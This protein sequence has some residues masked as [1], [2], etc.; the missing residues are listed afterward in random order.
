MS[1]TFDEWW[2]EAGFA[3]IDYAELNIDYNPP[4]NFEAIKKAAEIIW[5]ESRYNMTTKDN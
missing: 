4:I 2:E 1:K 5:K 3:V